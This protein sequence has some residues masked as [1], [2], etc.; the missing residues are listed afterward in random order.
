[1][2]E[3]KEGVAAVR[4]LSRTCWRLLQPAVVQAQ[5]LS[6]DVREEN[7][8]DFTHFV[9]LHF[10]ST[11]R[12]HLEQVFG[13]GRMFVCIQHTPGTKK[14]W[15]FFKF[16]INFFFLLFSPHIRL[17]FCRSQLQPTPE[18]FPL[19]SDDSHW[20]M[21]FLRSGRTWLCLLSSPL[22]P[23]GPTCDLGLRQVKA[24]C[25]RGD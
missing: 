1:M 22:T 3:R 19:S 11:L 10:Y 9:L 8:N 2:R 7:L 12:L 17:S 14:L 15:P 20:I 4:L 5:G 16:C 23:G 18:P 13:K 21:R 6:C 25:C 24:H